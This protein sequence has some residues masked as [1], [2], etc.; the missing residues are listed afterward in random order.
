M[1][2]ATAVERVQGSVYPTLEGVA[3]RSPADLD[4]MLSTITG[5]RCTALEFQEKALRLSREQARTLITA[6]LHRTLAYGAELLPLGEARKLAQEF[7]EAAGAEAQFFSNCLVTD[8]V[9]GVGG[10]HFMV[11]TYTFESVLYCMGK[12]ESALLV[13]VDED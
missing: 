7:V 2:L 6:T 3:R 11:T 13:A 5:A 1:S 12:N 9:S 4:E 8:E 10:R